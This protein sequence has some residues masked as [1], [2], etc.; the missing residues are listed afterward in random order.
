MR[1]NRYQSSGWIAESRLERYFRNIQQDLK[2]FLFLLLLLCFYRAFFMWKLSG[3]MG[4]GVNAG[5][6]R[7]NPYKSSFVRAFSLSAQEKQDLLEFLNTLTDQDFI[8]NPRFANP[9]E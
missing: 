9:W 4:S 1:I 2:L 8:T 7:A 3:F 5:D 6:G